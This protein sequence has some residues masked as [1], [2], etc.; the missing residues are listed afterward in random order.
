MREH[1]QERIER[2]SGIL[3]KI[4]IEKWNKIVGDEPEWKFIQEFKSWG[5]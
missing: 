2:V 1:L 4:G 5:E 3:S